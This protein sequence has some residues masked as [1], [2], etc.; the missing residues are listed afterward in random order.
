MHNGVEGQR[1]VSE[2]DDVHLER[3]LKDLRKFSLK[4]VKNAVGDTYDCVDIRRQPSL[5]HPSLQNHEIQMRPTSSPRRMIKTTS[6]KAQKV[7]ALTVDCPIGTVPV[8][9]IGR[10]GLRRAKSFTESYLQNIHEMA[11]GSAGSQSGEHYAIL[12]SKSNLNRYF[13]GLQGY[14]TVHSLE[15]KVGPKQSSSA[16]IWMQRATDSIQ[17]GWIVSPELNGDTRTHLF[18]FWKTKNG[19][20]FNLLCSAGFVQISNTNPVDLVL[21]KT[22]EIGD[23][24]QWEIEIHVY[25]DLKTQCWWLEGSNGVKVGYWPSGLLPELGSSVSLGADYISWGGSVKGLPNEPSPP[26]GNGDMDNYDYKRAAS[27]RQLQIVDS[28]TNEWLNPREDELEKYV[29]TLGCYDLKYHGY[30]GQ[31]LGHTFLYG[32]VGGNCT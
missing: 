18:V 16:Q 31:D 8:R 11:Q 25:L 24:I 1:M 4:T 13:I 21:N 27:F 22:A 17:T 12:R 23:K 14:P 26:M 15:N 30:Q 20:C 6:R 32:G 29:D 5:N 3:Q 19:G 28:S 9:R 2:E 7:H 10:E